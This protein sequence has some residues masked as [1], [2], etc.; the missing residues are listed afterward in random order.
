[1]FFEK[2]IEQHR[3]HSFVANGVNL[4]VLV[5]H[6][7]VGVHLGYFLGD[8]TKLRRAACIAVVMKRN[9]LEREN[10]CAGAVHWFNLILEASR[11]T[12]RAELAGGVY[13]HWY[14]VGVSGCHLANVANKA[15]AAHVRTWG[16]DSNNVIGRSNADAGPT[17]QGRVAEAGGVAIKRCPTDGRVLVAGSVEIKRLIPLAVLFWPVVLLL[18]A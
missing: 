2:L 1:M 10:G 9:R 18:S 12:R 4:S 16:A 6:H 11:G 7:Q 8:Q 14:G 5:A 17:P 15:A 3:V 13:Q